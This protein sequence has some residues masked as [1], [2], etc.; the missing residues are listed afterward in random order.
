MVADQNHS[1]DSTP[2]EQEVIR[3]TEKIAK[4]LG[5][6]KQNAE[7]Y[8]TLSDENRVLKKQ[9]EEYHSQHNTLERRVKRLERDVKYLDECVDRGDV[10]DLIHEI[11]PSLISKKGPKGDVH[12]DSYYSSE[13]SEDSDS[14]EIIEY[15]CSISKMSD[16]A[17]EGYN[18]FIKEYGSRYEWDNE[19]NPEFIPEWQDWEDLFCEIKIYWKTKTVR[20]WGEK[21]L[22][23]F[24]YSLPGVRNPTSILHTFTQSDAFYLPQI[25]SL[26]ELPYSAEELRE[27]IWPDGIDKNEIKVDDAD[28]VDKFR[29]GLLLQGEDSIVDYYSKIKRCNDVIKLCKNHLREIFHK[30]LSSESQRYIERFGCYY[31]HDLD[32]DKMVEMLIQ[33]EKENVPD[34]I[35]AFSDCL[36]QQDI[37]HVGRSMWK[38]SQLSAKKFKEIRYTMTD[39]NDR[40]GI[41]ITLNCLIVPIGNLFDLP[42]NQVAQ[43]ITINTG[44]TV[45][46]LEIAIRN[47]LNQLGL[48]GVQFSNLSLRI[49]QIHPG[50]VSERPMNSQAYI[51]SFF[52][53]Q[54]QPRAGHFHVTVYSP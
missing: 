25:L 31:D 3:R 13:S 11:V 45:G 46:G 20:H 1:S 14:V 10:V 26:I 37:K 44:R 41:D 22:K 30:G 35:T 7:V 36:R 48:L 6:D 27:E 12:K 34:F 38:F 52:N 18:E 40:D 53:D 2:T 5:T 9:L 28:E 50:T 19:G 32:P 4:L 8:I 29:Y 24:V 17:D 39:N 47:R 42:S 23:R 21:I 51:S 54:F 15:N 33:A 49:R 16:D 43:E